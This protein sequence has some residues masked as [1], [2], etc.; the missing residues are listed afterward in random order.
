MLTKALSATRIT[1]SD[2][3]RESFKKYL[4]NSLCFDKDDNDNVTVTLPPY[5]CKATNKT[6]NKDALAG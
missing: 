2:D 6:E 4:F 5:T 3:E 1:M